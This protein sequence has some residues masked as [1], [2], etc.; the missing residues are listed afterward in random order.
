MLHRELLNTTITVSGEIQG[1]NAIPEKKIV[2]ELLPEQLRYIKAMGYTCE[3]CPILCF[4]TETIHPCPSYH[5]LLSRQRHLI[6]KLRMFPL[7]STRPTYAL[8]MRYVVEV[9]TS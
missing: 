7:V 8:F 5:L 2:L 3:P 9:G 6:Q 1:H 4:L